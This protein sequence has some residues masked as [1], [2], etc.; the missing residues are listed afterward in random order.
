MNIFFYKKNKLF[1][2]KFYNS[3]SEE[4]KGTILDLELMVASQGGGGV[5]LIR[6][7]R[8]HIKKIKVKLQFL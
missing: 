5:M 1:I 3:S 8:K 6:L 7:L 4:F 2:R